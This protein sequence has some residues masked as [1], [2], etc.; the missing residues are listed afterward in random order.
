MDVIL[1]NVTRIESDFFAR[2]LDLTCV[3]EEGRRHEIT[4]YATTTTE[5]REY[6]NRIAVA[7]QRINDDYAAEYAALPYSPGVVEEPNSETRAA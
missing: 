4:I 5:R 1:Y 6:F 2:S 7:I 3:D